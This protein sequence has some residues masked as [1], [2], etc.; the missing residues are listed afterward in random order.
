[1]VNKFK[2]TEAYY[3]QTIIDLFTNELGYEY[4]AGSNWQQ[5][6]KNNFR[7]VICEEKLIEALRRL[8]P[9]VS[10]NILNK[11]LHSLKSRVS[12]NLKI[13]MSLKRYKIVS[14]T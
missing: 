7:D 14:P 12:S 1:M 11:A 3:E 10:D 9:D 5:R 8:N 6:Q 4:T 13:I 2:F